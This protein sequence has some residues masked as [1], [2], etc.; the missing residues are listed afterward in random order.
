MTKKNAT[1]LLAGLALLLGMMPHAGMAQTMPTYQE[2]HRSQYHYT[3]AKNWMNDPN[4]LVYFDGEYHL[5]Y[6]YNPFGDRWGHMSWGHAVSRDLVHWEELPVALPEEGGVMIFSGSAVVDWNNTSGFGAE[7]APPLVAIYT[8]ASAGRQDQRIAYSNDRGRTWT[9]YEGNPVLDIGSGEFRDPKVFWYA[10]EAKWV[11]VVALAVERKVSFYS[12]PDLK[13]WTHLSDFGP[14]GA[15]GGVWECP[16]LFEL[17]VDGDPNN[18]RWVLEVDLNPGGPAGGSGGQYFIGRFDGTTFTAESIGGGSDRTVLE[19]DLV[20]GFEGGSYGDWT[21]SGTAFGTAPAPG[22]LPGQQPV[23]GYLGE[24][25]VNSFRD[26]DQTTGTLTSPEFEITRDYLNFLIGGGSHDD[27]RVELIVDGKTVHRA[28]GQNSEILDWVAWDVRA[29]RGQKAWI[30]ILD[31]NTGGWGHSLA[32]HFVLSD[33]P[34]RSSKDQ[35]RWVDYGADF[36]AAV[37]WSDVPEEDGR[38]MWIAWMNNWLYAQDIPTSPWRSAQSLPRRVLLRTVDDEVVLVQEPVAELKLLR[39]AQQHLSDLAVEGEVPLAG[40][41]IAGKAL[42]LVAEFEVGDA[43]VVGLKVR[44]GAGEE[45]LVGYD[46]V[47]GKV[48]VDRTNSGADGF[49]PAFA[50]RHA[51]PLEVVDG[52]VR[53]HLFVDWSSVELFAGIGQTVITDRV[54]PSP[55]SEGVSVYA[56]GG[57]ARLV[58]LD[59]WKLNAIWGGETSSKK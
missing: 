16:D 21:A 22:S 17:P 43:G 53:L 41:G 19:G 46:V 3:P 59:V 24:G 7:D 48:F 20:A 6:Q 54:F 12:S 9:K 47:A 1:G 52:R 55:D 33:E 35:A 57:A 29:V 5:F 40:H 23:M 26:G 42:E 45:T 31:A 37:S 51:G 28:S 56:E 44:T 39:G 49:H 15:I 10:P 30:R 32:D 14:T 50:A 58:S 13:T 18:T 11:M 27:T 25:L 8:G 38:R 2:P 34:A 4:G 36:Y